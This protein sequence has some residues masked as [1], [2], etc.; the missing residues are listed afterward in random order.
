M[1][2]DVKLLLEITVIKC[3]FFQNGILDQE[4]KFGTL[5][6]VDPL[7]SLSLA[8]NLVSLESFFVSLSDD[9]PFSKLMHLSDDHHI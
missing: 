3:F 6:L 9:V 7:L 1:K 2:N 5:C 4:K 8:L